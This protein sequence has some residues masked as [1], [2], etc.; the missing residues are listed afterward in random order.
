MLASENMV[1]GQNHCDLESQNAALHPFLRNTV[2][3][4]EFGGVFLNKRLNRANGAPGP[5]GRIFG[6][7]RRTTDAAELAVAVLYQNPIQNFALTPNNLTDAPAEAIAFLRE[8]PTT[9]DETRLIDGYPGRNIVLAR[10]HGAT[11]YVAA[12]NASGQ[13]LQ[14]DVH[15]IEQRLGGTARVY[16]TGK[17]GLQA[18]PAAKKPL[19]LPKDDGAVLVIR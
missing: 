5:G 12:I 17:D 19:S 18:G 4:M 1:F 10:R 6:T 16:S 7:Q 13:P 14:L 15:A 8:V 3:C 9:W 2:G 11:W